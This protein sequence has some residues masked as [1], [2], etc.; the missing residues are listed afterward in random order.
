VRTIARDGLD[1]QKLGAIVKQNRD[2][3]EKEIELDTRKLTSLD[4]FLR[5]TAD[6]AGPGAGAP[7]AGGAGGGPGG[8]GGPGAGGPGGGMS[9][10]AFADQRRTYLLSYAEAKK[11]AVDAGQ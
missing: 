8:F 2:L 6:K 7:G 9:L 10:R 4:A 11:K 3:I 5:L 1:W